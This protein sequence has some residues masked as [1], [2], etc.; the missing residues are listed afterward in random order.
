MKKL[1]IAVLALTGFSAAS[2]AQAVPAAKKS[3]PSKMQVVK[4]QT[5]AKAPTKMVTLNKVKTTA[6][7]ATV[8]K[9]APVKQEVKSVAAIKPAAT[10][11][12]NSIVQLKKDGTPDKRFTAK[13]P[14]KKDGTP[15]MRFKANKK[16]S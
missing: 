10:A 8:T 5:D 1:M 4:K 13:A 3:A 16:H 14:V 15:D 12:H 7:T 6:T 11:K 2:F 9:P